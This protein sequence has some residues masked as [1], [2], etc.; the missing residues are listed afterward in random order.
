MAP[1]DDRL[2]ELHEKLDAALGEVDRLMREGMEHPGV[3]PDPEQSWKAID[4][5]K[6]ARRALARHT[7]Q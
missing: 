4:K 6:A 5:A 7:S 1:K 3:K 2:P